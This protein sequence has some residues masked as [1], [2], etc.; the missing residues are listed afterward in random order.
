MK[1]MTEVYCPRNEIQNMENEL[2]NLIV[3]DEE[4]KIERYIW[5][6]PDNIQ[7][8]VTS[9]EPTRLQY[10]IR[11]A[12]RLMEQ[13]VRASAARQAKNKR[14]W[15]SNQRDNH[16][17]Q[18]PSKRQNVVRAYTAGLGEKKVYAGNLPMCN[19]CK[20]YHT[21]PCTVKCGNCKRVGHMTKACRT[22]AA[23]TNQRSPVAN[24]KAIVTC[25]ECRKQGHYMSECSKLK[26]QNRKNQAG[27]GEAQGRV[28]ALGGGEANQDLDVV[29]GTF[30]LNNR[31]ASILFD[32][33]AD[34]SFVSTTFSS[35]IDIIPSA[36]DT[37]Y[38]GE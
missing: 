28:Y 16:V 2:W 26:N 25:Y 27:N 17:Q 32:T 8:N 3:R 18:P 6:L 14:R 31:Y 7:G 22:P 5:G 30:L 15:D 13:K 37:K 33:S 20:L 23:A 38:D 29:T 34:R 9:A 24:Q 12:N 4:L 36:L 19:K 10:A 11:L 35:L 21:G 1:M